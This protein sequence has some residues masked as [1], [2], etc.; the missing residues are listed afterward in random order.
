MHYKI[1]ADTIAINKQFENIN[2]INNLII[3]TSAFTENINKSY[4]HNQIDNQYKIIKKYILNSDIKNKIYGL[5]KLDISQVYFENKYGLKFDFRAPRLSIMFNAK[6][7]KNDYLIGLNKSNISPA[8]DNLIKPLENI[9]KLSKRA[10]LNNFNIG[11]IDFTEN[12]KINNQYNILDYIKAIEYGT[13]IKRGIKQIKTIYEDEGT[14][15]FDLTYKNKYKFYDKNKELIDTIKSPKNSVNKQFYSKYTALIDK[16]VNILRCELRINNKNHKL[17]K[18][19]NISENE[20]ITLEKILNANIKNNI[21]YSFL[22][23]YSSNDTFNKID[24]EIKDFNNIKNYKDYL[25]GCGINQLYFNNKKIKNGL[26]K[27]KKDISNNCQNNSKP[28]KYNNF[29]KALKYHN[30]Y[31]NTQKNKIDYLSIYNDLLNKL[32]KA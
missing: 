24:Y 23:K 12:I 28:T 7:L 17:Q 25:M 20:K 11:Y 3:D 21:P 10:I 6:L 9:I 8:L 30:L 27:L 19:L 22:V 5:E 2:S 4:I 31:L 16:S 14:L 1:K 18:L 13:E 26:M 29:K 32:K 15:Y